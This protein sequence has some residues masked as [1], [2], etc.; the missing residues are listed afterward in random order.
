M[1]ERL[2]VES[3][4]LSL[5]EHAAEKGREAFRKYG[6]VIGW[7]QLQQILEDRTLVRYPCEIQFDAE[8]LQSGEC[9]FPKPRGTQPEAGFILCVH[10][11]FATQLSLVPALVLYQLVVVNYGE[12]AT[13]ADAEAFGASALG[14]E[15]DEFYR[16]M[17]EAADQLTTE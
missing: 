10:P 9:V 13:A 16:R 11:L 2:T 12:F 7:T 1:A 6:P 3:A 14:L 15:A 5:T 8:A 17:C 4:R